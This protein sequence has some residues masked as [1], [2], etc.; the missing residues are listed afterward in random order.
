MEEFSLFCYSGSDT[1]ALALITHMVGEQG[2]CSLLQHVKRNS[3]ISI[4]TM[5]GNSLQIRRGR[6][7]VDSQVVDVRLDQFAFDGRLVQS[8][9]SFESVCH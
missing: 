3:S 1:V 9:G 2:R 4:A 5:I 8:F 7:Q 6:S